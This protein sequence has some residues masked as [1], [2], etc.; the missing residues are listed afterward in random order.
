MEYRQHRLDNGLT[1]LAECNPAGHFAA[2]GFFVKT[3]ARDE[4]P[5]L[6]GVSHF[7]EHMVFKGTPHR[8][9]AEVNLELDEMGSCSNART[10]EESTIYH[11]AVLPEF[12]SRM[13]DLLS[14]IMRPSLRD[15]DFE[16]ERKVILEEIAMYRD[17][18]P[19]G[20]HERIMA[21]FFGD[22][23]L[24][25]SVLGTAETVAALT[26][27]QM[28][29]YFQR[30]YGPGNMA[31]AAAGKIDF[32]ALVEQVERRCGD[33]PTVTADRDL[34]P[35]RIRTGFEYMEQ[36]TSMQSYILQLA[37]GPHVAAPE[38]YAARVAA[39]II[40]DDGGSRMYWALL[41][42]GLAETAGLGGYEYLDNGLMFTYVSCASENTEEVLDVLRRVQ[43]DV[44]DHG[45]TAEELERAKRKIASH[46][47]LA[48]ERTESRMFS[49]G[50]QWL[51]DRPY[52][53]VA[54][55]AD[56]YAAVTL[57]EVNRALDAMP[58]DQNMT[59]LVGPRAVHAISP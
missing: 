55:I 9:A 27:D 23:P 35:A 58:L 14:D 48:S 52:Q 31:L 47:V 42:T 30:R 36:P 51:V 6:G 40:G 34:R 16:T 38:R 50:S 32:D 25:Q 7:L 37:P 2:F 21:R 26:P 59:L 5:E 41:D 57:D 45:L 17:Q 10:S 13:I 49:I 20:G 43:A 46:I 15:E 56:R 3:G 33:W 44:R 54:E 53:S 11:A 39:S 24:G 4:S 29:D 28:R 18:P 22:H 12:Q 19:Y 8:T 1:I